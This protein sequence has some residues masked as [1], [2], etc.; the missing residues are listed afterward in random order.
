MLIVRNKNAGHWGPRVAGAA[1]HRWVN[2]CRLAS[3]NLA[4]CAL[5]TQWRSPGQAADGLPAKEAVIP[6]ASPQAP[7]YLPKGYRME[8]YK[9]FARQAELPAI[10]ITNETTLDVGSSVKTDVTRLAQLSIQE[11]EALAEQFGVPVGVIGK[12][13]QRAGNRPEPDAVQL[14]R[15]IRTAVVDYRFLQGEWKRY[16]PPAECLNIK[17]NAVQA[18]QVGDLSKAWQL[19]D[20][21][22]RPAP[23]G[24]LRIIASP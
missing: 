8:R 21:L 12:V 3:R 23:P 4:V 20:G 24:N 6:A 5:L 7:P 14:A 13:V 18:L 17:T 11:M 16:H 10:T 2:V 9:A 1:A 22:Q 15:D 19:Y